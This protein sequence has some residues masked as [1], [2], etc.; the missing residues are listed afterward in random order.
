MVVFIYLLQKC[1]VSADFE[2]FAREYLT[3]FASDTEKVK[4]P[5]PAGLTAQEELCIRQICQQLG[6]T[7]RSWK[8]WGE[9]VVSIS[10]P[11]Q[12]E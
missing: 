1:V 8:Q 5:L 12:A 6:L 11:Q 7:V 9:K 3:E 4:I 2:N 10:K